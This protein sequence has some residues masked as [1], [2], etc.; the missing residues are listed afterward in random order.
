M[1]VKRCSCSERT[2]LFSSWFLVRAGSRRKST[3]YREKQIGFV[4]LTDSLERSSN[5]VVYLLERV[6]SAQLRV[7]ADFR[8]C[9]YRPLSV[10]PTSNPKHSYSTDHTITA[11]G[12][13]ELETPS[14]RANGLLLC[15]SNTSSKTQRTTH[16]DAAVFLQ[17]M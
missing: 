8:K 11:I 5:W 3:V 14:D 15:S 1:Y 10:H 13:L 9:R 6:V 12:T 4:L 7:L 17:Y 2:P 16:S